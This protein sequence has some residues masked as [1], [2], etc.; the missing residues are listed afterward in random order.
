MVD[1]SEILELAADQIHSAALRIQV[2]SRNAGICKGCRYFVYRISRAHGQPYT[3]CDA[4][5]FAGNERGSIAIPDDIIECSEYA[6]AGKLTMDELI[7]LSNNI[8]IGKGKKLG[9]NKS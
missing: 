1:D 6:E 4:Y 7:K 3:G 9:F 2:K 5:A 8:E